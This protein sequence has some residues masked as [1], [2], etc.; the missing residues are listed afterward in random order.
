MI[1]LIGYGC[2]L[3]LMIFIILIFV[4]KFYKKIITKLEFKCSIPL[5]IISIFITI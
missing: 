2:C 1:E 4:L 5:T 3:I